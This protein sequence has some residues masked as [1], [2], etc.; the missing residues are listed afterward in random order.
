VFV[1]APVHRAYDIEL[2]A[3]P[4][5][6]EAE[7]CVEKLGLARDVYDLAQFGSQS[8]TLRS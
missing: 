3:I 7:A 1:P 2:P 8:G 5:I 4:V 6:A